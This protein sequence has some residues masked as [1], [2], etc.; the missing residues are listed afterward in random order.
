MKMHLIAAI[1][2]IAVVAPSYADPILFSDDFEEGTDSIIYRYLKAHG[3][4]ASLVPRKGTDGSNGLE[5]QYD[6]IR[7][8][9]VRVKGF[10]KLSEKT[11]EASLSY[12]VNFADDF[13]WVKGGKMHGLGPDYPV[14]GDWKLTPDGWSSRIMWREDGKIETVLVLQDQ[15][16]KWGEY[17]GNGDFRFKRGRYYAVT[18]Y[19]KLNSGPDKR[20]GEARIYVDG[21]L[22]VKYDNAWF[23]SDP[24]K[25]SRISQF[26]FSTFH[27]GAWP[28]WAP[29]DKMGNYADVHAT[30]DNFVVRKGLQIR[31]NPGE[32]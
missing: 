15:K 31:T 23:W 14:T 21:K 3:H 28:D 1:L 13:Q 11:S 25:D 9:S 10:F 16:G 32:K 18:L 12:D 29:K 7:K 24:V 27:G 22:L 20:D 6:S 17:K 19:T 4:D 5:V 8:G 26:L 30:F 2:S